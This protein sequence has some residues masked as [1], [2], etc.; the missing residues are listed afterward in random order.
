MTQHIIDQAA[1][2]A[3]SVARPAIGKCAVALGAA[4]A[5]PVADASDVTKFVGRVFQ[6]PKVIHHIQTVILSLDKYVLS[7]LT[8][9][10]V[11]GCILG[12]ILGSCRMR[13]RWSK[14]RK[15]YTAPT[16][17]K[18]HVD[19][20]CLEHFTN[21]I[22]SREPCLL[23]VGK[24]DKLAVKADASMQAGKPRTLEMTDGSGRVEKTSDCSIGSDE[25]GT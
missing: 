16:G 21:N 19:R 5:A 6:D 12:F 2:V 22:T 24:L 15:I 7:F 25:F 18:Y 9:L 13:Y 3:K 20:A 4:N 11:V 10:I 1:A 14:A 23:C 8:L 17:K